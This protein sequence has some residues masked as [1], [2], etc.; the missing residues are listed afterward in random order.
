MQ[1]PNKKKHSALPDPFLHLQYQGGNIQRCKNSNKNMGTY[2]CNHYC[3]PNSLNPEWTNYKR[4]KALSTRGTLFR[5]TGL[6]FI[7]VHNGVKSVPWFKGNHECGWTAPKL[8]QGEPDSRPTLELVQPSQC[9]GGLVST[10]ER[11]SIV[12]M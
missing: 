6:M 8:L 1:Q 7:P 3:A 10:Q 2:R 5:C 9:S 12:K 11:E 4:A